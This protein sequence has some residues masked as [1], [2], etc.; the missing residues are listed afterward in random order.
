MQIVREDCLFRNDACT[1]ARRCKQCIV[2]TAVL[3]KLDAQEQPAAAAVPEPAAAP[4][5]PPA[6]AL[7]QNAN[8]TAPVATGT[9]DADVLEAAVP[10]GAIVEVRYIPQEDVAAT[11]VPVVAVSKPEDPRLTY[12]DGK[13]HSF[14]DQP[15][16]VSARGR[17]E[18]FDNGVRHRED[19]KPAVI[20]ETGEM[21]WFCNGADVLKKLTLGEHGRLLFSKVGDAVFAVKGVLVPAL[22]AAIESRNSLCRL[23]LLQDIQRG[24]HLDVS[25][26]LYDAY[27]NRMHAPDRI[28]QPRNFRFRIDRLDHSKVLEWTVFQDDNTSVTVACTHFEP[29]F[30]AH[31]TVWVCNGVISTIES[32][33][34]KK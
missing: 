17:R 20:S 34:R 26:E 23:P 28:L 7:Q 1:Q 5:P 33:E 12:R 29:E 14:D 15:A 31:Q 16:L 25:K 24:K 32:N 11:A 3:E 2:F 13:L 21:K 30:H 6:A 4:C 18:W 9:H 19:G 8:L 10:G 27:E 22:A